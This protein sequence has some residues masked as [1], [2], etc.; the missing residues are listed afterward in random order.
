MR[1]E[2]SYILYATSSSEQT[3]DIMTFAQFGEGYLVENKHNAEEYGLI[4][5]SIYESSTYD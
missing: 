1:P 4:L 5:D 2:L 3:S